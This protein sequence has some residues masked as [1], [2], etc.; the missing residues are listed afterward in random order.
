MAGTDGM[1]TFRDAF[2]H[3]SK[4]QVVL[5]RDAWGQTPWTKIEQTAI[6]ER[7]LAEGWRGLFFVMLEDARRP[8]WVPDNEIHFDLTSFPMEQLVGAIKARAK[9]LGA[10]IRPETPIERARRAKAKADFEIETRDLFRR[11]EGVN[12]ARDEASG[13]C[14]RLE[15]ELGSAG[16]ELEVAYRTVRA[17][18][19]NIGWTTSNAGLMASFRSSVNMLDKDAAFEVQLF[20][21]DIVLPGEDRHY[22]WPGMPKRHCHDKY[23]VGRKMRMGMCW[24]IHSGT[25]LS[26]NALADKII[27]DYWSV[28][29]ESITNPIDWDS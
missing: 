2:R 27:D 6:Q 7:C 10:E 8:K 17:V 22:N 29:E 9:E 12:L 1:E 28:Y 25:F 20:K 19:F 4:M 11:A 21:H 5:F 16:D 3:Q 26:S 23:K 24:E 18:P 13:V 15:K 14:A